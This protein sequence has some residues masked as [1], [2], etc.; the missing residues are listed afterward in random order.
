MLDIFFNG[1]KMIGDWIK[2]K[3]VNSVSIDTFLTMSR[4]V[5]IGG[6]LEHEKTD[7][8]GDNSIHEALRERNKDKL[9][10][11]LSTASERA[12]E[13]YLLAE[14]LVGIDPIQ[15]AT[16][17]CNNDVSFLKI[18][19][20]AVK[21]ERRLWL[22]ETI[23]YFERLFVYG[24]SSSTPRMIS[25]VMNALPKNARFDFFNKV[26]E[27]GE[28]PVM[29]Q[30]SFGMNKGTAKA[31]L[32]HCPK[33]NLFEYLTKLNKKGQ[34][35]LMM[36]VEADTNV[37]ETFSYILS[38]IPKDKRKEFLDFYKQG[39][40]LM[41][42]AH[43]TG[44]EKIKRILRRNGI[45]YPKDSEVDTENMLQDLTEEWEAKEKFKQKYGEFPLAVLGI[46][47]DKCEPHE[48][49]RAYYINMLKYHPDRNKEESA[50]EMAQKMISAYEFY[51]KPE[52]RKKYLNPLNN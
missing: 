37:D 50:K 29:F 49:K 43:A 36:L 6:W 13:K 27:Y 20:D 38:L 4:Y 42:L 35:T 44:K 5:P 39:E 10:A 21:P 51:D 31:F 2:S 12:I 40:K 8:H 7:W 26:D 52:T 47:N 19:L 28:T 48:I 34:T 41:L 18:L 23:K 32:E 16:F 3:I 1:V 46:E 25:T 33:Q 24:L 15:Y 22:L 14:N 11:I 17:H 9:K 30:A 45:D